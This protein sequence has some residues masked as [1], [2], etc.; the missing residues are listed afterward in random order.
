MCPQSN[1]R[2]IFILT[3]DRLFKKIKFIFSK[4]ATKNDEIFTVDLT[5][6]SKCQIVGEDFISL[7]GLFRK[8]ELYSQ[9]PIHRSDQQK[10]YIK[11]N[12]FN[13]PRK[14]EGFENLSIPNNYFKRHCSN[15]LVSLTTM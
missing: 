13:F 7:C 12:Q 10:R 11:P 4:K 6:C 1:K 8:H 5:L 3:S 2:V 9:K 14:H 15:I